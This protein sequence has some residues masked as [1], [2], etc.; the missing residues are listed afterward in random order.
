MN[1]RT[2]VVEEI[3]WT[4]VSCDN[5]ISNDVP[6][7]LKHTITDLHLPGAT[8]D[9]SLYKAT[10]YTDK[11]WNAFPHQ[12]RT[13]TYQSIDSLLSSASYHAVMLVDASISRP[14]G[15]YR[16]GEHVYIK[17]LAS[18]EVEDTSATWATGHLEIQFSG[19]C[20]Y[21]H[22]SFIDP[23]H[24]EVT[25]V[26]SLQQLSFLYPRFSFSCT[27]QWSPHF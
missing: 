13:M 26:Q 18:S 4:Q 6:T 3:L 20:L 8:L 22:D 19:C 5:I 9:L 21:F 23:K 1:A 15:Q 2:G 24:L 7:T 12:T 11:Q 16:A 27:P 10:H 25:L 14:S 17:I